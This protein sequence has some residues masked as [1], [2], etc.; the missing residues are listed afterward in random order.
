MSDLSEDHKEVCAR[1]L[2]EKLSRGFFWPWALDAFYE[3]RRY[4]L[5]VLCCEMII[6]KLK[7]E[8]LYNICLASLR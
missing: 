3:L 6:A 4:Q 2:C 5:P 1:H 7:N 8:D